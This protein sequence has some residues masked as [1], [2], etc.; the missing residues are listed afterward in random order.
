MDFGKNLRKA[1][2]NA[3]MTQVELAKNAGVSQSTLAQIERGSKPLSLPLA[4][5]LTKILGVTVAWLV[6]ESQED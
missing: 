5:E 3:Q 6:G 2:E 1:R 4:V